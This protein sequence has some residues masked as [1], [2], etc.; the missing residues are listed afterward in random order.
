[1][2][3]DN[4]KTVVKDIKEIIKTN[5]KWFLRINIIIYFYLKIQKQI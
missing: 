4:Y 3:G 2:Y 1:M 5:D